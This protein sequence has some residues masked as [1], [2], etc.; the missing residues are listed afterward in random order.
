MKSLRIF[1]VLT[2]LSC[3]VCS[4]S[5]TRSSSGEEGKK[6]K[7][8]TGVTPGIKNPSRGVINASGD[9]LTPGIGQSNGAGSEENAASIANNAIVRAN[10]AVKGSL[11]GLA[12]LKDEDLL[13]RIAAGQQMEIG[14]SSAV[15]N[16][17]K[18]K[19][20]R[21]YAVMVWNDHAALQQELKRLSVQKN[22]VLATGVRLNVSGKTD[23]EFVQMMIEGNQNLVAL[24]NVA[25]KSS[26]AAIK[27]F[28]L[29]QLPILKKHLEAAQE[30]TKVVM[31]K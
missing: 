22:I 6:R 29:K 10:A 9:G 17:T 25:S 18:K 11:Q 2:L 5:S 16:T 24:Y 31:P 7:K 15:Q 28:A 4:C 20:I 27:E 19:E 8:I 26:D 13:S 23:L 14:L 3:L 21:D 12:L 30:L 1:A